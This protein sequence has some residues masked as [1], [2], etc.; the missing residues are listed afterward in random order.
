[1]IEI[2]KQP[3]PWYVVGPLVSIIMIL[4]YWL[5]E[6]FGVSS[7]CKSI[8]SLAGAGKLSNYFIMDNKAAIWNFIFS[9]FW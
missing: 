5:G 3:W 9:C 6:K 8:C 1:M 2:I 4:M 7:T